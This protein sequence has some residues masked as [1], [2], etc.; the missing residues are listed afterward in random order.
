MR[1]QRKNCVGRKSHYART[2]GLYCAKTL[3]WTTLEREL[4]TCYGNFL[5]PKQNPCLREIR[6]KQNCVKQGPSIR[7]EIFF[8]RF[9]GQTIHTD[10]HIHLRR[11]RTLALT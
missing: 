11:K 7:R 9:L 2:M 6:V 8:W 1:G 5:A 3:S 4:Y 10:R